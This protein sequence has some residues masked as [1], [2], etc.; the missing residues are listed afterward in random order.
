MP[1]RRD[2]AAGRDSIAT[3][4]EAQQD[5]TGAGKRRQAKRPLSQRLLDP[6]REPAALATVLFTNPRAFP[7]A[8]QESFRRGF[9]KVWSARGGGLYATGFFIT[10]VW[11][12]IRLLLEDL[13]DAAD[14]GDFVVGQ[15]IELLLRFTVESLVNTLEAFLWPLLL[16]GFRP[17]AGLVAL[18]VLYVLF[19]LTLKKP[20]EKWLFDDVDLRPD[21]NQPPE[22]GGPG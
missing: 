10:F 6:L 3:K 8:A 21:S 9:R 20:L 16:I 4:T 15:A 7:R 14:P 13:L 12:E 19:P 1:G 11:L 17:P 5:A 2:A 22:N 18:A